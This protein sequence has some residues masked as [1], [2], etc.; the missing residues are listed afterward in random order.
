MLRFIV[1]FL[2]AGLTGFCQTATL[3]GSV[4]DPSS[5]RVPRAV[6]TLTDSGTGRIQTTVTGAEGVYAFPSVMPG[7]YRVEVVREGFRRAVR[8]NLNI[9][10]TGIITQDFQLVIGEATQEVTVSASAA[11]VERDMMSVGTVIGRRLLETMP[12]NGRSFQSLIELTPGVTMVPASA[13]SQGQFSVNGQRSN[14]NYFLVDGVSGNVGAS[15]NVQHSQFAGGGLPALTAL[16]GSN[17][18]VSVD[19]LESSAF[20]P[21]ASRRSSAGCRADR[22]R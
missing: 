9:P 10:V 19:A 22:F 13:T 15:P 6:V 16:G 7:T 1:L 8:D 12:L 4:E 17:S 3:S 14:A 18:L 21:R 5:A 2:L 11:T 20:R